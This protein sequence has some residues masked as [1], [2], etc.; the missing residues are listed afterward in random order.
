MGPFLRSSVLVLLLAGVLPGQRDSFKEYGQDAGLTNL[1]VYC[2][3]QD[4]TGFLWVGTE[5]GLFRYDGRQFRAYTK[6]QGLPS[7]QIE[8]LHQT[9][10]GEIWAGTSQGLARLKG[11]TFETVRSGPGNGA[12]V[13]ASDTRGN[14]YVG[15]NLGLLVA[16]PAGPRGRREFHLHAVADGSNGK[17]NVYGI[18][19]ESPERVWYGCG[20][21][22][23][24]WGGG[25][26]RRRGG[27]EG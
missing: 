26:A 27:L 14:L 4:R 6:A 5:N 16:A 3:M 1:D 13:I 11:D 18:A 24:C 21:G 7:V 15:T 10:D 2:L 19:V 23:V 17:Q 20:W 12:H 22:F 25:G 8:A 9:V